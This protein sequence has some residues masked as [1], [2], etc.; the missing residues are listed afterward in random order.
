MKSLH[1]LTT[2]SLAIGLALNMLVMP[3]Q[4]NAQEKFASSV[5]ISTGPEFTRPAASSLAEALNL[6]ELPSKSSVEDMNRAAREDYYQKHRID[7]T[8]HIGLN[9]IPFSPGLYQQEDWGWAIFTSLIDATALG[10]VIYPLVTSGL[11]SFSSEW[12]ILGLAAYVV[13]PLL[14]S[15][16]IAVLR[17]IYLADNHNQTLRERLKLDDSFEQGMTSSPLISYSWTF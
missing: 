6:T 3:M 11:S 15:R 17:G 10:L 4:A 8:Q 5:N 2:A 7:T 14:S 13:L 12:A 16:T 1:S 9:L